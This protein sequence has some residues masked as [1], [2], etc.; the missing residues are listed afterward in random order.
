MSYQS[1]S[2]TRKTFGIVFIIALL[3]GIALILTPASAA[4]EA[5]ITVNSTADNDTSG[6]GACTLRE[7][8]D[9]AND[10]ADTTGGD[11][12]AGSGADTII[13]PAG[14]YTGQHHH[15]GRDH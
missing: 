4:P 13:V 9:N 7:A 8:I 1:T 12:I 11:C 3:T 5:T 2:F 14:T 10:D 6:D 15:P